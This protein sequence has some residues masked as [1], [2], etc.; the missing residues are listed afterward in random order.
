MNEK[1]M[2]E[3]GQSD[4]STDRQD[5]FKN[6]YE[7]GDKRLFSEE[8]NNALKSIAREDNATAEI[9]E[10]VYSV[11]EEKT[12]INFRDYRLP[13]YIAE[14]IPKLKEEDFELLRK[15]DDKFLYIQGICNYRFKL[16]RYYADDVKKRAKESEKL[17]SN[18]GLVHQTSFV[19]LSK[20]VIDGRFL[21][22]RDLFEQGEVSA[23]AEEFGNMHQTTIEDRKMGLDNYVFADL[24]RPSALRETQAEVTVIFEPETITAP[25]S[26]VTANDYLDY[27]N[28]P[29]SGANASIDDYA[30]ARAEGIARYA[31]DII[32][33]EHLDHTVSLDVACSSIGEERVGHGQYAPVVANA[34]DFMRCKTDKIY[35]NGEHGFSTWE[36]K[37]AEAPIS[38]IRRL[39]FKDEGQY[40]AFKKENG[41]KFECVFIP[42]LKE[43]KSSYDKI[44]ITDTAGYSIKKESDEKSRYDINKQILDG[45]PDEDKVTILAYVPNNDLSTGGYE[46]TDLS[47]SSSYIFEENQ[48]GEFRKLAP[49]TFIG[50]DLSKLTLVRVQCPSSVQIEKIGSGFG[51]IRA[52]QTD[53]AFKDSVPFIITEKIV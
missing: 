2:F 53:Y 29:P 14:I 6:A 13:D 39:I 30:K 34:Y 45:M 44:F 40:N 48:L 15:A 20:A 9:L 35:K 26:F 50:L 25:N 4:K 23:D 46:F 38:R 19:A 12:G 16:D 36:V 17:I 47:K 43:R 11:L 52:T 18:M 24:G 7:L 27:E 5:F 28:L 42:D 10:S 31:K 37:L 8:L 41:D 3:N 49:S 33:P 32:L 21:S 22:N 51:G 1:L